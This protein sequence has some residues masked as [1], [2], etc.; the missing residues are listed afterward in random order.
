MKLLSKQIKHCHSKTVFKNVI[1]IERNRK[2]LDI[3]KRKDL[4]EEGSFATL[5]SRETFHFAQKKTFAKTLLYLLP[6]LRRMTYHWWRCMVSYIRGLHLL[7]H[8]LSDPAAGAAFRPCETK[9]YAR[10]HFLS[11]IK[12]C[13]WDALRWILLKTRINFWKSFPGLPK[14]SSSHETK[15]LQG[16][17]LFTSISSRARTSAFPSEE[18]FWKA[19]VAIFQT[20]RAFKFIPICVDFAADYIKY[21]ASSDREIPDKNQA[22][23]R[24]GTVLKNLCR[25][26]FFGNRRYMAKT[27]KKSLNRP[28]KYSE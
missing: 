4:Q 20:P 12:V 19:H 17:L 16:K 22:Y 1:A 21:Q 3:I 11:N 18:S 8:R 13:G 24:K 7:S 27:G 6:L 26:W 28:E 15:A 5:C 10:P 2:D 14:A 25:C 23:H 9:E